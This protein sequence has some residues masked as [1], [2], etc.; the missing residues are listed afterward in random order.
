[1]RRSFALLFSVASVIVAFD[2]WT[3][4]WATENLA[5]HEPIEILGPLLRFTY[6]RNSG[7]AFGLG[8]GLPFPYYIFSIIAVVAI[9]YLFMRRAVH[10]F[11]RQLALALI[12]G[13]AVGNLIDRVT[14]GEVVDFIEIGWGR[15]HWP[16]FNIA[17]TAVTLGVVLFGFTWMGPQPAAT[18]AADAAP[19]AVPGDAGRPEPHSA[20]TGGPHSASSQEPHSAPSG[21][22]HSGIDHDPN[23]HVVGHGAEP[24]GA[25]GSLPGGGPGRPVA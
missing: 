22:P 20:R 8:A 24:R 3:K 17:D 9:L 23:A 19:P 18:P 13:G 4:R 5:R 10:T 25:A 15:W 14:T 11:P 21:G 7:V 6:T 2:W 16:V 12:L 1:V